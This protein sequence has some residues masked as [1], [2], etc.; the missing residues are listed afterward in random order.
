ME[1]LV[2]LGNFTTKSSPNLELIKLNF[3]YLKKLRLWAIL[4]GKNAPD[5]EKYCPNGEI[6][7]NLVALEYLLNLDP[8]S[9]VVCVT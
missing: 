3:G 2:K 9:R 7:P 4:F 5:A 6:T 1:Y 8:E